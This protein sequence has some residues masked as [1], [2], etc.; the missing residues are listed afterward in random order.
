MLKLPMCNA[1]D[2]RAY[3]KRVGRLVMN[4]QFEAEGMSLDDR[5][6][7]IIERL[8]EMEAAGIQ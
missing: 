3:L 6:A 5:D 8:K 1:D 7:H 4:M 2:D